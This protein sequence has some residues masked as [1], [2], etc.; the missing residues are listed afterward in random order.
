MIPFLIMTSRVTEVDG[1]TTQGINAYDATELN[2]D[3]H[4]E[5]IMNPIKAKSVLLSA[6]IGRL[7]EKSV[8]RTNDEVRDERIDGF[9]YFLLGALHSPNEKVKQAAAI[10]LELFEQY[11]QKMKDESYTRE[12]SM[13]N[14]LL[15][16]YKTEKALA[17]VADIP[18]CANYIAALQ[19]A[20]TNFETNRL[21]YESARG[22]EGTL[23]NATVLKKEMVELINEL[24][25]PYV[26][27]M[28]RLYDDT[29]GAFAHTLAEIIAANNEVVKKRRKKGGDKPTNED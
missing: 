28:A 11:G 10:L 14:S 26:N 15:N 1:T 29:Y 13:V 18:Q 21:S 5:K 4:L 19:T 23:E 8:Q 17:A 6:A 7:K 24:L 20:Q 25:V 27:V 3:V 22:Q 16:D 12:S 2:V 9:Y